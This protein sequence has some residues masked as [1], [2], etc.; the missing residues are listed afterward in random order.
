MLL[1]YTG[2]T[3]VVKHFL[4]GKRKMLGVARKKVDMQ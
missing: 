2:I 3:P 4:R 1:D